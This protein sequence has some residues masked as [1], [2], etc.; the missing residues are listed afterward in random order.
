MDSRRAFLKKAALL[1]GAAGLSSMLPASIER[2]MAITADPGTS[3]YDAEHVVFLM[4][5]NRSFD[6]LFGS[7]KG[8]RGFNDPRAVRL[9]NNNKVWL[10]DDK[11]GQTFAPFHADL[12]KTRVTWQG[13]LPHSWPDQL[14]ARNGG[15]YDN[16]VPAK[17]LMTMAHFQRQD[18]PFYYAL[19]DAFTICD[20]YFCSSLTG[21]TP[22]RLFFWTGTVRPRQTGTAMAVVNNSQAESRTN[23]FVDWQTFPELLE[24]NGISWKIYQNELWTSR[25]PE[26]KDEWL[27][28]YGD[29]AV[30]YIR[31]HRVKLSPWFRKNGDPTAK[32]PLSAAEVTARYERLNQREKNLVDKAFGTNIDNPGYLDL[33]PYTFT[34]DKGEKQTV[35]LPKEDIFYQFR[36]DVDS[37]KLP[38]VS[39]LVAPERFSDHTSAPFYGTWYVSEALDILTKNPEV[40]KKTIFIL[41]YDENDGY[42]DHIPPFVVPRH[43]EPQTG[44]VTA[45]IDTRPDF[46]YRKGSPIGLGYRVPML[47]ASPWSRG[48]F[49]NSQVFDHTSTL[50]FLENFLSKKTGRKIHS[51]NISSWRRAVCGDLSSVFRP[52]RGEKLRMPASL[53]RNQVVTDIQNAKNK[54]EQLTPSPLTP[55]E[56]AG[57]NRHLPFE[58]SAPRRMSRQEKGSS[59]ACALPYQLHADASL[60]ERVVRLRMQAPAFGFDT[61]TPAGAAFQVY[62]RGSHAG[63]SGTIRNYALEAGSVLEDEWAIAAFDSGVYDLHLH[64]PNGFFRAFT[65]NGDDPMLSMSTV[66]TMPRLLRGRSGGNLILR[67]KNQDKS[68]V[69]VVLQEQTYTSRRLEIPVRPGEE[70]EIPFNLQHSYGWYDF[71]VSTGDSAWSRQYAGHV[72][73]GNESVTDPFMAGQA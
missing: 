25:L 48:G 3:F 65:G 59:Q 47:V 36:Q 58:K 45:G 43:D 20:H 46:E 13:G 8:V 21:T 73:T 5:E 71:T 16:W 57:F 28:N 6:H 51:P 26:G 60:V 44:K 31:R 7:M 62:A 15:R 42:F 4:Q 33:E 50:L 52:Y 55:Q 39:W 56:I 35:D 54:P 10:Q 69:R 37:G 9:P 2:A 68:L 70:K 72:E 40:W 61:V 38:M 32:P 19:A 63:T 1:S 29:N 18:V 12:H 22:N 27:G 41:N 24:D 66:Y 49:V 23:T 11:K 53:Q 67:I 14:A 64:G 30:E 34:N 17:S